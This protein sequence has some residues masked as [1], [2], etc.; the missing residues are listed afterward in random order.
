MA[1]MGKSV[2]V[3]GRMCTII[4]IDTGYTCHSCGMKFKSMNAVCRHTKQ[5]QCIVA[6]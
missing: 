1:D 3:Y 4:D 2:L 6:P 5:K